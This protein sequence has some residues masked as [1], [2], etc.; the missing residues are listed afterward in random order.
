MEQDNSPEVINHE[1]DN[2]NSPEPVHHKNAKPILILVFVV[3]LAIIGVLSLLLTEK[4]SSRQES[5]DI[6]QELPVAEE[7]T[8]EEINPVEEPTLSKGWLEVDTKDFTIK[9]PDGWE[10]TLQDNEVLI[11]DCSDAEC[12]MLEEGTPAV[13][14]EVTGGRDGLVGVL[15]TLQSPGTSIEDMTNGYTQLEKLD[16]SFTRYKSVKDTEPSFDAI[17]DG[18]PLGTVEYILV[19]GEQDGSISYVYYS[20]LPEQS[21]PSALIDEMVSTY[22]LK[23]QD[24]L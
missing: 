7:A 3:L 17:G 12:Y 4:E 19:R 24:L 8:D 15:V 20:V 10:F 9:V 18:L 2:N 5:A 13:I 16:N 21:D 23:N 11:S 14:T 1:H 22:T 6:S